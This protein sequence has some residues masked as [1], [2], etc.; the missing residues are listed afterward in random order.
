MKISYMVRYSWNSI[1]NRQD[2]IFSL[3]NIFSV[4]ATMLILVALSGMLIAFKNYSESILSKIPLRINIFK[5]KD[6]LIEDLGKREP[7]IRRMPGVKRWLFTT[8]P[9]SAKLLATQKIS[10]DLQATFARH[11]YP[12][13]PEAV[14]VKAENDEWWLQD[15]G[16]GA[17]YF[18]ERQRDHLQVYRTFFFKSVPTFITFINASGKIVSGALAP[19]GCTTVPEEPL[20]LRDIFGN[21][22][23][24]LSARQLQE[25]YRQKGLA[26]KAHFDEIGLIVT[27]NLLKK[28]AYIPNR[29]IADDR[30]TWH[31]KKLPE[32]L[33]IQILDT[34]Q[35]NNPP[36]TALP[37][38]V[39][40][41]VSDLPRGDYLVTEDFYNI[42]IQWQ[43]PFRYMLH[44][45]DGKP[46]LAPQP[47]IT[48]AYYVLKDKEA[49]WVDL[50]LQELQQHEK[51]TQTR[52]FFQTWEGAGAFEER[53]VIAPPSGRRQLAREVALHL[54]GI[55]RRQ[56]QLK[57]LQPLHWEQ[58]K[59]AVRSWEAFLP[60]HRSYQYMQASLYASERHFVR[61]L[62]ERL[63]TMGLFASSPLER[64]LK[65][66]ESQER[67][68]VGVTLAIFVLVLFLSSVVLFSTFY[69]S[70]LRKQREIGIFKAYGASRF[71][72]LLLFYLQSSLIVC[73][74]AGLG[75]LGGL[76]SGR[77]FSNWINSFARLAESKL[78][79]FL[80]PE[81]ILILSGVIFAS[82]WLA[83]FIPARIATA[84]DP[85]QVVR[86]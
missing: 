39:V 9:G 40:A 8:A 51:T 21:K 43:H 57:G 28:L 23:G 3:L 53:L 1:C 11:Q 29:A 55:F 32:R 52:I 17:D 26:L 54:D 6:S 24:W 45:R 19:N 2:R 10:A 67:F 76:Q 20:G 5:T 79:F 71:L 35:A 18:I 4:A 75:I 78:T 83:I 61:P 33:T 34:R 80:P 74:G 15:H 66:F 37:V 85:A 60:L 86:N 41:V 36:I 72:V 44:D 38:P 69:T 70:V 31:N 25:R 59:T 27:F 73:I 47:E 77:W 30:S 82:C 65:T 63:R 64:Y 14:I 48:K 7:E 12:L 84:V 22:V 62:L 58:Q 56:P 68:F 13:T 46:L 81:L 42:L 16:S 50:H 49:E